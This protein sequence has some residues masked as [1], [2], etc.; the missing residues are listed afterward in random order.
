V[1]SLGRS[2]GNLTGMFLDM[3]ELSRK[4][5]EMLMTALARTHH[6]AVLG[7]PAINAPQFNATE[8]AAQALAVP[9]QPL[10]MQG[11]DD[12]AVFADQFRN[13]GGGHTR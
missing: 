3:P 2:G 7:D 8:A 1:T 6:V 4:W 10:E 12:F 9:L 13:V 11:P 5:L